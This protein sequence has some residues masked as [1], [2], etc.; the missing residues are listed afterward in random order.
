MFANN[1]I[2][3]HLLHNK[4]VS[5]LFDLTILCIHKINNLITEEMISFQCNNDQDFGSGPLLPG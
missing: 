1:C 3:I 4:F 5:I 2:F